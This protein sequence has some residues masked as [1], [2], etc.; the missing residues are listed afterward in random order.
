MD[1]DQWDCS[2]LPHHRPER[3]PGRH[4]SPIVIHPP[5]LG[6]GFLWIVWLWLAS[7]GINQTWRERL[8]TKKTF[9]SFLVICQKSLD[10]R[11]FTYNLYW[12][13]AHRI[14][15]CRCQSSEFY[16]SQVQFEDCPGVIPSIEPPP[17]T[18]LLYTP[19]VISIF[20]PPHS[21]PPHNE[22]PLRLLG[23][24]GSE[25]FLSGLSG[26]NT[27]TVSPLSSPP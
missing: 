25:Q 27:S 5:D 3:V 4:I 12:C 17:L 10:S 11:L 14:K 24:S 23:R 21:N 6:P 8:L 26:L 18:Y 13:F 7:W 16:E 15:I 1:L 9:P 22:W 19:G 20:I 2:T